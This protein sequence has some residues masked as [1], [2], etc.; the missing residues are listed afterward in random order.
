MATPMSA[1]FRAGASLTPS[2]VMATISPAL[3]CL[4]QP[5]LLLGRYASEDVRPS[6]VLGQIRVGDGGELLARD[7]LVAVREADLTG[8]GTSGHGMVAGD[9]LGCDPGLAAARDRRHRLRPRRV[10]QPD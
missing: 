6:G 10:N 3:Q 5:Q 4:D 2:P 9:H 8:D 7:H 1:R